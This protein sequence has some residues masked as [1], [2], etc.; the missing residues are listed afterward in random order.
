MT[1]PDP[2]RPGT[3]GA[4]EPQPADSE[5]E[6]SVSGEGRG[7]LVVVSGPSGAGKTS[8]VQALAE[9][10]AF[11]FSV[12]WTTRE[13]R[14][15]ERDG[16]D[17]V[18]VD[19]HEFEEAIGQEG[20]LEWAEYSGHLY[21]TPRRQVLAH[22]D[23]GEH[24]LL[25]IENDGAG[26]VKRSYPEAMLI[27]ILPPSMEE[28]EHRLRGRGDTTDGDIAKRLAVADRQIADARDNY[29]F[30]VTNS[31]VGAAADEI[32]SILAAAASR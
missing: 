26:Q 11:H 15:G 20:F 8:V 21:G 18:F 17:Y 27:F 2:A 1:V 10:V 24:V 9:R 16:V 7:I 5:D 25:D 28:L 19:R 22:L 12:S 3:G 6:E 23:R 4:V 14:P 31:K 13:Q 29:D 30:L 32:V